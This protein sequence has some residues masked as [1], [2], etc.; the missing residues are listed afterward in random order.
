MFRKKEYCTKSQV[1][2]M[3]KELYGDLLNGQW[4]HD[5][6]ARQQSWND[7]VDSLRKGGEINPN[8]DWMQPAFICKK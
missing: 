6:P 7:F 2:D 5:K 1:I 4:K 3:Y 8:A